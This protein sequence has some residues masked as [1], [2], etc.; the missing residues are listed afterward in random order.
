VASLCVC[1]C[2]LYLEFCCS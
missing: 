2:T 1:C